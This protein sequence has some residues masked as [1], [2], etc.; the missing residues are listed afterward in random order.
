MRFALMKKENFLKLIFFIQTSLNN[1][2]N[3]STDLSSN[4]IIYEFKLKES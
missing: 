1:S 4:E 2:I 3:A